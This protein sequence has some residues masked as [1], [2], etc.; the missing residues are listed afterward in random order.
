MILAGMADS[1]L[2]IRI[3]SPKSLALAFA[4]IR[5]WAIPPWILVI[6]GCVAGTLVL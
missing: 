2:A 4:G 1:G 3:D 5:F 6:A